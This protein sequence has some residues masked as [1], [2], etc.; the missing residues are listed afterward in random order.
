MMLDLLDGLAN[1]GGQIT[2]PLAL[3][4]A[5]FALAGVLFFLS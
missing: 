5:A 1:L 4:V 3:A 2:L